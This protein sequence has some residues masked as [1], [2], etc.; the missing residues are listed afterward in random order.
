MEL[1]EKIDILILFFYVARCS[2]CKIYPS[3]QV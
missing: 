3:E 1:E 2:I